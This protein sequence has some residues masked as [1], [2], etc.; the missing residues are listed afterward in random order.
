MANLNIIGSTGLK[1][2]GGFLDEEFLTRLRGLN[3]VRLYTE[4]SMNNSIV[5][6]ILFIIDMI[7]RQVEWRFETP[8][9]LEDDPLALREKEFS[10]TVID[11]MST[12]FQD[13]ISE[14]M[15]ILPFGWAFFEQVY[16]LRKGQT[17]DPKTRSDYEDGR[18]GIRKIDIRS[19]DTLYRW[20]FDEEN[21]L[22]GMLQQDVY[23]SVGGTVTLPIQKCLLLRTKSRK[24][25]PEGMSLLRPAVRDWFYLKRIQDSEAVGIERDLTGMPMMEVPVEMLMDNAAPELQRLR[26]QLETWVQQIRVDERWG[27]LMP[28]EL[29]EEGKPTGY[30]FRLLSTGGRRQIDTNTIVKRYES[31]IAMVFL[32]E[33][34]FIGQDHV[35]TQ[36][37]DNSKKDMFK[38]A[39]NTV[40]TDMIAAPFNKFV[41]GRLMSL[42][43]VP[44]QYWPTIKPASLDSPDLEKMGSFVQSLAQA[45]LLSP[46]RPLEAKL[47]SDAR[48]PPPADEEEELFTDG[49]TPTPRESADQASGIISPSQISAVMDINRAIKKREIT[50]DAARELA[51]AALGMDPGSVDRFLIEEPPP[52]EVVPLPP[53]IQPGGTAQPPGSVDGDAPIP[54]DAQS[55]VAAGEIGVQE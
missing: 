10:E 21:G 23:R 22:N 25:N 32:A 46:N 48:L 8:E 38:L 11:D 39:L 50:G 40:L 13:F 24:G 6:A 5:G 20:L 18:I 28:T 54:P 30:R 4:M 52:P 43:Q 31:R 14:A 41:I 47:L 34:L 37:A 16:K 42:N 26:A 33:F 15:S 3:G 7:V 17:K 1:Q 49:D 36:S 19:Q 12:S 35:G 27:G 29:D 2:H 45:G 55:P 9:G 51:A 44:R 53:Q